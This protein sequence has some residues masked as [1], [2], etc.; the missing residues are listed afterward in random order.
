MLHSSDLQAIMDTI[1]RVKKFLINNPVINAFNIRQ[2]LPLMSI[3]LANAVRDYES[4]EVLVEAVNRV[5]EDPDL[6][7]DATD[8]FMNLVRENMFEY[9]NDYTKYVKLNQGQRVQVKQKDILLETAVF[10]KDDQNYSY[11]IESFN[12]P[13]E[14]I[15]MGKNGR[16]KVQ[17]FSNNLFFHWGKDKD[18]VG[19][20]ETQVANGTELEF[21]EGWRIYTVE[22]SDAEVINLTT[23]VSYS[24]TLN[25]SSDYRWVC[26]FWDTTGIIF[27]GHHLK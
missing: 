16:L 3:L 25:E 15:R 4:A 21:T 27:S 1:V 8:T 22:F 17:A 2:L 12:L 7:K 11:S 5:L 14:A 24:F 19:E 26:A 23:P 13:S 10:P 6:Y 18:W 20:N 9:L